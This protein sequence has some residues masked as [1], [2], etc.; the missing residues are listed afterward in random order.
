MQK[1]LAILLTIVAIN[2]IAETEQP[3]LLPSL[4]DSQSGIVS[5]QQEREIGQ[6]WLRLYRSRV[7]QD[8]DPQIYDYLQHLLQDLAAQ[9]ALDDKRLNLVVVAN[10]TIN[11]FAVPGGVVGVH[12][13]LFLNAENEQELAAV[14]AHELAHL[15][16]RHFVRSLEKSR[17]NSIPTMAGLLAGLALMA[18]G[19]GD[20]GVA[21]IMATQ[22]ANLES[23]LRFSRENEAEAD[24]VGMQ[25][26]I[27]SNM[28][29]RAMPAMFERMQRA[30]RFMGE[31]PPEFLLSHPVTEKRI[32]DTRN[33]AEQYSLP[34]T[35]S[36]DRQ[37]QLMRARARL[38]LAENPSVAA[39]NFQSELS[40]QNT[41]PDANRYGLALAQLALRQF[42][43]ALKTLKPLRDSDP[44]RLT[45]ILAEA[46]ILL[47]Q[48]DPAAA[49][50]LLQPVLQ[51][52]P[53]NYPATLLYARALEAQ[54]QF[55][56][57]IRQLERLLAEHQDNP[58]VWFELAEVRGL[59][60]DVGGVHLARAEYFMLNG[61][62]DQARQQLN[63]ALKLYANDNIQ[64]ARIKQRLRD[65]AD[66]EEQMLKI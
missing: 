40:G 22:A 35:N 33:R 26:L 21:A 66:T 34:H 46:E 27:G 16:Q 13:G 15:S 32:A 8:R 43:D 57:A 36:D 25:T 60:G 28:D 52:T 62:L 48:K 1:F 20:A 12:S 24:R 3:L 59:A 38:S 14:L 5:H 7:P 17:Q 56:P 6:A 64:S 29:P 31:R 10:P 19:G 51:Q 55:R 63:Y 18:G 23:Q 42:D 44:Q 45:Y 9:S 58:V 61:V 11:A 49:Q 30:S 2:A 65:L 53:D 54:D 37:Y 47:G 41:H 39:R 4:G 50:R